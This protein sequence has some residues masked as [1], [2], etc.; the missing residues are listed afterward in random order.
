MKAYLSVFRMRLRMETQYRGAA[1]GG[2][3]CQIFFGLVLI[4]LYRALYAGKPQ[5]LPLSHITTYVW[6][7]Q[8]FFRMLVASD[9]DLMDKIRTGGIAYD[10]CRPISL[11]GFYY[12]RILA[13]KLMGIAE[14][15][16][17]TGSLQYTWNKSS[18]C[19]MGK[20]Q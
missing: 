6:L 10:L 14:K 5:T 13:Q 19:F 16:G 4:A 7:Q 18:R 1:L 17:E 8:A 12:A 3:I 11:Y 9:A 20:F 15:F 2:I